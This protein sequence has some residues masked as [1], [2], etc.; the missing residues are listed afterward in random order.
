VRIKPVHT[1]SE[2]EEF[3]RALA[4]ACGL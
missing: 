4:R 3:C 1:P 2:Y